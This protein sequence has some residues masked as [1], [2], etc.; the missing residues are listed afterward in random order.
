MFFKGFFILTVSSCAVGINLLA[1]LSTFVSWNDCVLIR[2]SILESFCKI[3][4]QIPEDSENVGQVI[5][6]H[7][8][9]YR[10]K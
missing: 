2:Q 8:Q 6:L 10:V 3:K 1:E 5:H 9:I 4:M 7:V